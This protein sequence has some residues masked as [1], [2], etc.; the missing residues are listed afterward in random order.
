VIFQQILIAL[1]N[2]IL[3]KKLNYRAN[4]S[5]VEPVIREVLVVHS[6]YIV[7]VLLLFAAITLGLLP[8]RQVERVGEI[9]VRRDVLVLVVCLAPLQLFY[10][11]G[12]IRRVSP[13]GNAAFAAVNLVSSGELQCGGVFGGV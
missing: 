12:V 9:P 13:F 1:A 2:L 4:L 11:D 10:S 3:P 5:R 6:A 7:G 8:I